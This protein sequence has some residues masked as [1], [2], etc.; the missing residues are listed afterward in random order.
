MGTTYYQK[1]MTE[2]ASREFKIVLAFNKNYVKAHNNLG[3]I[4]AEKGLLNEAIAE[5][6][7]VLRHEPH[8]EKAR[9]NLEIVR[10]ELA[11]NPSDKNL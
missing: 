4:Y 9:N 2:D 8:N 7:E 10:E 6:E 5:F 1:G 3:I 11:R